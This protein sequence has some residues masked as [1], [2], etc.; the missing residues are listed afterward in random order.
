MDNTDILNNRVYQFSI[1]VPDNFD[2]KL[3]K[4]ILIKSVQKSLNYLYT[5]LF[6]KFYLKQFVY[7]ISEYYP[8]SNM[9]LVKRVEFFNND[10]TQFV[11]NINKN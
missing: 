7:E 3:H 10:K 8:I 5:M 4:N 9:V 11:V 6:D 2:I 1:I